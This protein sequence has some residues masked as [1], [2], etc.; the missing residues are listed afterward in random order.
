MPRVIVTTA[1]DVGKPRIGGPI[2]LDAEIDLAQL[3]SPR[4][5]AQFLERMAL[6]LEGANRAEARLARFKK[7]AESTESYLKVQAGS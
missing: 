4:D 1:N 6:A 7:Q 2:L 3:N 5:A